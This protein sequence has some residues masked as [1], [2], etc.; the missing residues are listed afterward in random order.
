MIK[1]ALIG[2]GRIATRHS[3]LLGGGVINGASLSAVCDLDAEKAFRI[4]KKFSVPA[5]IDYHEMLDSE[6]IDVVVILTES[7]YHASIAVDVTTYNKFIVI[8]KPMALTIN[9]ARR[10]IDASRAS[11]K[12]VF[13]VKQNRFNVPVQKLYEAIRDNKFGRIH[14]ATVRVRWCRTQEYYNQASWRGTYKLDGGVISNQASHHVD[15]LSTILGKP[16]TVYSVGSRSLAKIEAEDTCASIITFESGAI[17]I[18]EAS[19]A[20]RPKDLEGSLSVLGEYGSVVIDGFAVNRLTTWSFMDTQEISEEVLQKH[21]VN[22]PNVYGYGHQAYYEN[23]VSY[24]SGDVSAEV[25]TAD[26]GLKTLELM[27]AI[28]ESMHTNNVVHLPVETYS[29]PLGR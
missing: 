24:L 1:F 28:Y 3:E 26:Q 14:M 4:A 20:T 18:V 22:P 16:K 8:E 9:D 15:L 21:S 23:L 5:Y 6:D 11:G 29:T 13:I 19:T 27:T 25:V 17:G 12:E 10:I 7:G 2:C